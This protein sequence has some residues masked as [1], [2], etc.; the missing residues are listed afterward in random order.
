MLHRRHTITVATSA[1]IFFCLALHAQASVTSQRAIPNNG[2]NA[3]KIYA[4]LLPADWTVTVAHAKRLLIQAQIRAQTEAQTGSIDFYLKP[5]LASAA[6]LQPFYL[7]E[8][9]DGVWKN[10]YWKGA[11]RGWAS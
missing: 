11:P 5:D 1:L 3:Y 2:A 7:L 8:K 10:L 6:S 9:K 4:S